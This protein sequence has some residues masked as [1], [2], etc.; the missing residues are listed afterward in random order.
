[1]S[2]D[3]TLFTMVFGFFAMIFSTGWIDKQNNIKCANNID[4]CTSF[5]QCSDNHP[6]EVTK[7]MN[8]LYQC[9]V[10]IYRIYANKWR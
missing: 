5:K 9:G 3:T 4:L 10:F 8:D 1:M 2:A 7:D 6:R